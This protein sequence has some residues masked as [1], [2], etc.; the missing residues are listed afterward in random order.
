MAGSE[1]AERILYV[2]VAVEIL[3][4][5]GL[6]V[7]ACERLV[8][9]HFRKVGG[10]PKRVGEF[11]FARGPKRSV[12]AFDQFV[13]ARLDVVLHHARTATRQRAQEVGW[14][15]L[16]SGG[17]DVDVCPP[18]DG[19]SFLDGLCP[20]ELHTVFDT[21]VGGLSFLAVAVGAVTDDDGV[22]AL[23]AK[24]GQREEQAL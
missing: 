15:R 24:F 2:S 19:D 22:P 10:R 3:L 6:V 4:Q 1:E 14:E 21:E 8:Y 23:V 5:Y 20:R 11:L 9:R 17:L 12:F 16:A 18:E 13:G 7:V